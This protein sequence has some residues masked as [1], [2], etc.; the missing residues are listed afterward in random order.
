MLI[1]N[2]VIS[3]YLVGRTGRGGRTGVSHTFFTDAD[4]GLAGALVNV[5]QEANQEVPQ[6]IYKYPMITKKKQ[7]KVL[8]SYVKSNWIPLCH[9]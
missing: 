7:S 5:L 4:K 2:V 9:R 3:T 6:E 8:S 1:N